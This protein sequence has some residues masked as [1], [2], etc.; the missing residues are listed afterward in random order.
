VEIPIEKEATERPM[1]RPPL[2]WRDHAHKIQRKKN[3]CENQCAP[4]SPDMKQARRDLPI[5]KEATETLRRE[6]P[7]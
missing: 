4:S 5:E 7:C 3:Q 6:P 1:E 2:L